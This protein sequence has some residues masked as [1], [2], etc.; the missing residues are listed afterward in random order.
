M[1]VLTIILGILWSMLLNPD[2]NTN[3]LEFLLSHCA[4]TNARKQESIWMKCKTFK[5]IIFI[6]P[7][8]FGCCRPTPYSCFLNQTTP[9]HCSLSLAGLQWKKDIVGWVWEQ[10]NWLCPDKVSLGAQESCVCLCR[11]PFQN[12]D[13]RR[14]LWNHLIWTILTFFYLLLT[15]QIW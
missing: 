2:R 14:S 12:T 1:H 11:L 10:Q 5:N 6:P 15:S 4:K 13:K 9:I 3:Y 8:T 7:L